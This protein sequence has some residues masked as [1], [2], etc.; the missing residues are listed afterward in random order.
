MRLTPT[1]QDRLL[2]FTAAELARTRRARGLRLNVPEATALIADTVCE[3]ARD[4]ARL[5]EAIAAGR[6]VLEADDVL[7][8]VADIVAEIQVEAVFEDG[9]RLAV[10]TDPIGSGSLGT[11][12]PGAIVAGGGQST[13]AKPVATVEVTNTAEVPISVTSHF[14][15]FEVNPRLRFDRAEAYGRRAAIPAGSTLRFDPGATVAVQLTPIGGARVAVGFAG[16]VDGPLDAP[17]AREEA[18]RRARACGY[19][20]L[21]SDTGSHTH[22]TSG[23]ET[24][25]GTPRSDREIAS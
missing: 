2:L 7:P 4:G 9:T 14:H 20:D 18:L 17:G 12:A 21:P 6:A 1:E 25:P 15:F 19:L 22:S 10:V 5:A 11:L 8:G 3:A 16:L 23:E 13:V 24:R